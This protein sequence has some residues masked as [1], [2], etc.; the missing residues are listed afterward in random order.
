MT[1]LERAVG[2]YGIYR[3]WL[4]RTEPERLFYL[5]LDSEAYLDL[6]QDVSGQVLLEDHHIKLIV[7]DLAREELT[8]WIS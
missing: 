3:S 7:V 8:E 5:A 2:Q 4:A 1:E 6:F